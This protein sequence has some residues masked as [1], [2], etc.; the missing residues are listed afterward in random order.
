V[1]CLLLH[2]W[3]CLGKMSVRRAES[4][5]RLGRIINGPHKVH[6]AVI[7]L[8]AGRPN[9][10]SSFV[11]ASSPNTTFFSSSNPY[12]TTRLVDPRSAA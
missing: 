6:G 9:E 5:E 4:T 10:P 11:V 8:S 7:S 1:L 2:R 12:P 3:F